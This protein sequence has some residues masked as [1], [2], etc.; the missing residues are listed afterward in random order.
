MSVC[1]FVS[2][3]FRCLA[4]VVIRATALGKNFWKSRWNVLDVALT[5]LCIFSLVVLF[6]GKCS[7]SA[8]REAE[9]DSILLVVRNL[10]QFSRLASLVRKNNSQLSTRAVDL[11]FDNIGSSE[12]GNILGDHPLQSRDS[13]TTSRRNPNVYYQDDFDDRSF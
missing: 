5:L 1:L 8:A 13:S 12:I 2:S 10:S 9:F 4:E 3:R 6:T 7:A 11:D